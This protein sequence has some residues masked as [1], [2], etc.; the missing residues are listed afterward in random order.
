[1]SSLIKLFKKFPTEESCIE[2][3]ENIRW[4]DG[5]VCVYCGSVKVSKHNKK[6]TRVNWQCKDCK[7]SFSV[8]VGT[9]FHHTHLDLRNWF[10]IIS[11]M[12]SAKKGIS[13][14]QVARD[15]DM[16]RPTVWSVMRRVRKALATEQDELLRGIFEIDETYVNARKEDKNEKDDDDKRCGQ[17]RSTKT[18]TSVVT[19]NL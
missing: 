13:A 6:H 17:G 4:K 18:H 15:L 9:I 14:C 10:Y 19:K 3:L 5:V 8:T 11:L 16:R 1:M 12:L 7:K 2:F